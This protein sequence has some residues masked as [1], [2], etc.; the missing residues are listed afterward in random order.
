MARY[1][2][3]NPDFWPFI[4]VDWAV[5]DKV[6]GGGI[7]IEEFDQIWNSVKTQDEDRKRGAEEIQLSSLGRFHLLGRGNGNKSR[8]SAKVYPRKSYKR[9]TDQFLLGGSNANG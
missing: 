5:Y 9:L 2:K 7:S 1:P 8:V 3:K 6:T 4:K